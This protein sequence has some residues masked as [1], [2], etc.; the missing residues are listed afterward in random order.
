MSN[1]SNKLSSKENRIPVSN[2]NNN[3]RDVN[4][5][6][7]FRR[8]GEIDTMNEKYQ[9]EIGIEA[10]WISSEYITDYDVK[11]H[12]NPMLY[13]ENIL[14]ESKQTIDYCISADENSNQVITE[15]RVI[16]GVFWERLELE[17]FPVI[18]FFNN[19]IKIHQYFFC[20]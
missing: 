18:L 1:P 14:T 2:E 7:Q 6:V 10:R 9:A 4:I 13:I 16:K 15:F 11:T 8:I 20:F 17:N 5:M 3:R 12:W 19:F